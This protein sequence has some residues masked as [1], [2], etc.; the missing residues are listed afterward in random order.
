MQH[1]FDR[2]RQPGRCVI[3]GV[4]AGYDAHVLAAVAE[5]TKSDLLFVARDDLRM[6]QM[7]EGLAFFA[8]N[9][10]RLSIPAWDNLPYDRVSPNA[11]IVSRRLHS[12][13]R[14]ALNTAAG[15][16]E[17]RPRIV[18][19]T[20]SAL[21]QR[22]P[23]REMLAGAAMS[24]SRG[25]RL[26]PEALMAFLV[27]SG[28]ARDETVTMPGDFAA[29][30]GIVDVFPPGV[31]E[32]LRFDFFGDGLE[33]IRTFDSASQRTTGRIASVRLDPVTE[34]ILDN[35]AVERFRLAY[36]ALAGAVEAD[37]PL[38]TAVSAGRRHAGMEHWLPLFY[39]QME[40]LFDYLPEAPVILD[41]QADEAREARLE[42]IADYY[43]ARR[44]ADAGRFGATGAPY[45]PVAPGSAFMTA[46]EWN[47]RAGAVAMAR[48]SP[49]APPPDAAEMLDAGG[50]PALDF[51]QSRQRSDV[52]VFDEVAARIKG[53]RKEGRRVLIAAV[54][55]GS[56]DRLLSVF[57]DHAVPK[58]DKV[59]SWPDMQGLPAKAVGAIVLALDRG[60]TTPKLAVI[61][62]TDI[63]GERI[64]RRAARR[65]RPENFLTEASSLNPGDLV[66]HINH[67]VGRYEGL[68]TIQVNGASHDCLRLVYVGD[69][70]LFVPVEN[71]D[72]IS[73]YGSD[74]DSVTLD[75]LGGAA[76]QGRKAR[77]KARIREMADEL[78]KVAAARALNA[79][80]EA[81]PT[82]GLFDEFCARFPYAETDDQARAI[83]DVMTDLA[84]GRPADRLIC[85]D[86]G[87]G[88]TEVALR[89]A[90]IVALEGRQ[91]AIVVPTT[92]LCR[93]HYQTFRERFRGYPVRISEV[94]R[95]IAAKDIKAAKAGLANGTVDIV[96]GT[97]ALL[98]RDVRFR[99]LGLLVIDEEQHFGV[100]HKERLK[101]LKADVHVLSLTATPIPRTLQMALSGVRELSLIATPPVDRLA[102]RTFVME[103]D[104]V[105][106]REALLREHFRGGQTFYVCPRIE[107]L[108]AIG[109]TLAKLVP[110]VSVI[111]AHGRMAARDLEQSI[112]AFYERRFNV[113][114]S[115][116]IIEFRPRSA[117]RQHH[118]HP[119]R[120]HVRAGTALSAARPGRSR[121]VAGLCLSHP[122]AAAQ[123]DPQRREALAGHAVPRFAGR[124][125]RFGQS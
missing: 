70:R 28:Y 30:G 118:C 9:I 88:K 22:V 1:L 117:N 63:L 15:G 91:V 19:T 39:E 47:A 6:A 109:E 82:P 94:S 36:R 41:R 31:V 120:R 62:E 64:S 71:I 43:E 113:L 35:A 21:L 81:A 50:R 61:A 121:Q 101:A 57:A 65:V 92:L 125:L 77:L 40:T 5:D 105:V 115:T 25:D 123:A 66:V 14:L 78:I 24:V 20:V 8:P 80:P 34:V 96:V 7:D 11:E 52:N 97:H 48:L 69:D 32:P 75:R 45:H 103:Q 72:L 112:G 54:S 13:V 67:G 17:A 53:H 60:F 55:A 104:P 12:L 76:W 84:A 124:R 49:F 58:P 107:D 4:P 102:V 44:Q 23:P 100:A 59:A 74:A 93:Q 110:E 83:D 111:K 3:A 51:A 56:R 42:L 90:F 85:G 2:L 89:A 68:E 98:A 38:Y 26:A 16:P 33:S 29:R 116:N 27:R 114:L 87:F 79:A 37:N 122:T 46:G 99:D 119:P 86:V 106:I 73:R 18:L 108:D 95:L 10:D